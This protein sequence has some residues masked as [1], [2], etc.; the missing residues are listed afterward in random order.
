MDVTTAR[1]AA[2]ALVIFGITGLLSMTTLQ[3]ALKSCGVHLL[4]ATAADRVRWWRGHLVL[5]T[6]VSG[7]LLALGLIGL[8]LL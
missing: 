1:E 5:A 3:L 2:A 4:P 6:A 8:L 7:C